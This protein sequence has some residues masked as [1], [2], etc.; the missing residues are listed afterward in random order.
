M[1]MPSKG[2]RRQLSVRVPDALYDAVNAA[3]A[4]E[5]VSSTSQYVADLLAELHGMPELVSERGRNG[6]AH[7][8]SA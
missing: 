2:G 3:R 5:G 6:E 8:L 7:L 1:P 4:D